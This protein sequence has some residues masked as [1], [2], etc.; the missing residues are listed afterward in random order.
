MKTMMNHLNHYEKNRHHLVSCCFE[1][2]N[3]VE[4]ISAAYDD[5]AELE[6]V[7]LKLSGL[8]AVCSDPAVV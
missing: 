8:E 7:T 6:K 5:P 2:K 3:M 4:T 1:A